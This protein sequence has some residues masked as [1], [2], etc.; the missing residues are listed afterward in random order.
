VPLTGVAGE[1]TESEIPLTVEGVSSDITV[2]VQL[3][4][5]RGSALRDVTGSVDLN[6]FLNQVEY[7]NV[8]LALN[9]AARSNVITPFLADN[10]PASLEG[11]TL[12]ITGAFLKDSST[13]VEIVPIAMEVQ[14]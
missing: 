7:L 12:T 14:E 8:S 6:S 10:P 11:T 3:S 2:S 9:E 1:P 13:S 4:Q 5:F